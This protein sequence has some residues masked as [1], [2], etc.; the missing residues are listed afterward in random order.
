MLS[1][2]TNDHK[3]GNLLATNGCSRLIQLNKQHSLYIAFEAK[4]KG[5]LAIHR[6]IIDESKQK[7]AYNFALSKETI[8]L[9]KSNIKL[10]GI[11]PIV[12]E[13]LGQSELVWHTPCGMYAKSVEDPFAYD[14]K[15]IDGSGFWHRD[16]VGQV[17]KIFICV[18][19]LQNGGVQTEFINGTHCMDPFVREWEMARATLEP[20][21]L[22]RFTQYVSGKYAARILSI[23]LKAGQCYA[24]NTNAVHRG[25]YIN[26][27]IGTRITAQMSITTKNNAFLFDRFHGTTDL[28][29]AEEF[30]CVA[31]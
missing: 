31:L 23:D 6:S 22:L 19:S 25:V 28:A 17:V 1:K 29:T 30:D 8:K 14:F 13:A 10:A 9:L 16:S 12:R 11:G 3:G 4:V 21:A 2:S 5:D 24:F 20:D 18:D 15:Q 7:N 27:Q 26:K